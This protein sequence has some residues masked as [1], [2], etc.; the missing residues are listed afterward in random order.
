MIGYLSLV[1][2]IPRCKYAFIKAGF[3]GKDMAKKDNPVIPEALGILVAGVYL[4]IIFLFIPFP[5]V[6]DIA[7]Q[8][9]ACIVLIACILLENSE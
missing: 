4:V 6:N 7:L 2:L 9:S 3:R 1:F 8:V 5:F